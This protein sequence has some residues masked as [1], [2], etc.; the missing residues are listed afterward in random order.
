LE[1]DYV[2]RDVLNQFEKELREYMTDTKRITMD[3]REVYDTQ[4]KIQKL[5]DN[6]FSANDQ[7]VRAKKQGAFSSLIAAKSLSKSLHCI[8]MRLMQELV[9]H[10]EKY[11]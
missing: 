11:V 10:P 5:K 6:L 7:L 2:D 8:S 1:N 3:A 9:A 4:V